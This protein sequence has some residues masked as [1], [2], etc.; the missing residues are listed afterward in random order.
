[1]FTEYPIKVIKNH[2]VVDDQQNLL[3]D[4]GS[5]FSF[6]I[7]GTLKLC[8]DEIAVRTSIPDATS[9]YLSRKVGVQ[10]D[11]ILGMDIFNRYPLLVDVKNKFIFLDDDAIYYRKCQGLAKGLP[12]SNFYI[13]IS[14][15]VNN[16][17]QR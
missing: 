4:T 13:G 10:I 6:H 7:L 5:P 15:M 17:K 2:I 1:M 14:I 11:G 12:A 9:S 8:G 16:K 3:I